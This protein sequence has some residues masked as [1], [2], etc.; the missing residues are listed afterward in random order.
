M[1]GRSDALPQRFE[2]KYL[3]TE[4]HAQLVQAFAAAYLRPDIHTDAAH[5]NQY[6]VYTLYL[7]SR[8]LALY[9]ST[10]AGEK[11]RFKLRVRCYD[12]RPDTLAFFEIKA[13]KNDVIQKARVPVRKEAIERIIATLWAEPE[14]LGEPS[15]AD[16]GVLE[17]F[18]GLC[19]G[20]SARPMAI[21]RYTREAYVD[22]DARPLRLTMDRDLACVCAKGGRLALNGPGWVELDSRRVVLE[23]KFTDT[24]PGWAR[25]MAQALGLVRTSAAKY[26][27]SVAALA[28]AGYAI[29]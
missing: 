11:N 12:D 9:H 1:L 20:L 7:D 2:Y 10:V 13:R 18:C 15:G 14:D 25:E 16:V 24:F 23:I 6:S 21:V 29:A 27:R 3:I 17:R 5:G 26:V 4:R 19:A 8:D 28:S 22:P